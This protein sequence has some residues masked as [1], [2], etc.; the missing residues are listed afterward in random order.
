MA[1]EKTLWE[2]QFRDLNGEIVKPG[3]VVNADR[4]NKMEDGIENAVTKDGGDTITGGVKFKNP[5][6]TQKNGG[7]ISAIDGG[8]SV[9]SFDELD[10]ESGNRQELKV[11]TVVGSD[12][13]TAVQL[14][15]VNNG[16]EETFNV[17]H[18]GNK[19]SIT[20]SDIGAAPTSHGT[21]VTYGTA[22]PNMD[23]TASAGSAS[24]VSRSDHK[25][26]TDTS[27]APTSHKS[28]TGTYGVGNSSEYG[29]LKL[30][31]A[32]NSS[33]SIDNGVASTPAATKAAY[34]LAHSANELAKKKAD[35]SH[36][37]HVPAT[38]NASNARFL[39]NDN[40]WQ[41]V[42]PSNIGAAPASHGNHVPTTETADN[43]KFLRNDNT[44]Q[45]VTPANIGAVPTGRKVNNKALSSDISLTA[46]DVGA[47]PT[48]R[49]VNGKALSS[50]IS[51]NYSD[52]GADQAGSAG[53]VQANLK[54]HTDASN[55][56]GIN[57][58]TIGAV[59]ITRTVNGK[60]L[61]DNVN[62]TYSDVGASDA[63]HKHSVADITQSGTLEVPLVMGTTPSQDL[64]RPLVR[65]IYA[66]T[67][68]MSAGTSPLNTGYIYFVYE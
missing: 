13:N 37:N 52:V 46:G 47:V 66:G 12:N 23:G 10:K 58:D 42:T 8:T 60:P 39:R 44:W 24:S 21:H 17:L 19:N 34:D 9:S 50:D 20:P 57:V 4:L 35:S 68:D 55:P 1:Y 56:H 3:T 25:H 41:T 31:D 11:N 18:S 65:N 27:R 62:L 32:T 33:N 36:G 59:P 22:E 15:R 30:S 7:R 29:H 51:L 16:K 48:G 54:A 2:D 6:A 53:A 28:A 64:T 45:T 38:E 63:G 61:S 26:P 67:T 49:K 14:K 43:A 40:T 5:T